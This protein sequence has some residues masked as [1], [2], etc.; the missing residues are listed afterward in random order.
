MGSLE[1]RLKALEGRTSSRVDRAKTQE[2]LGRMTDEELDALE[3][4]AAR[5]EAGEEPTPA[6][7]LIAARVEAIREE[8]G[9]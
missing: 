7:R 1:K 5:S 4:A 6:D 2:V 3:A 8:V 9:A